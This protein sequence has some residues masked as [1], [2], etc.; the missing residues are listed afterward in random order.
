M[1]VTAYS[2]MS[3]GARI[4]AARDCARLKTDKIR[5]HAV[6]LN[7]GTINRMCALCAAWGKWARPETSLDLFLRGFRGM[8]LV[9]E[10]NA[11]TQ[12]DPDDGEE[13][14]EEQVAEAAAILKASA[15]QSEP[16]DDGEAGDED[17]RDDDED[18]DEESNDPVAD[19]ETLRDETVRQWCD[20]AKS[21]M[22]AA[23]PIARY[24]WLE[25]WASDYMALKARRAETLRQRA[26]RLLDEAPLIA[27]SAAAG[28]ATPDLPVDD[29]AFA[30][31]GGP[32]QARYALSSLWGEWHSRVSHERT[33]PSAH[34]YLAYTMEDLLGGKRKGREKLR[35]RTAQILHA[36]AGAAAAEAAQAQIKPDRLLLAVIRKSDSPDAARAPLYKA[37]TEWEIGVLI[38]FTVAADWATRTFLLRVPAAVATRLI[39]DG[40]RLECV[41][42]DGDPGKPEVFGSLLASASEDGRR[43]AGYNAFLPGARDDTPVCQR[44]P[45]ALAEVRALREA[46]D[47]Q[48]QLFLVCSLSGGVEV[49][50]LAHVQERCEQ[51]WSG[52]LIA[53]ADDLPLGLIEPAAGDVTRSTDADNGSGIW[54]SR[55][56]E[57]PGS[58]KFGEHLGI[59]DGADRLYRLLCLR[60]DYTDADRALRVLALARGIH[61]LR[62]IGGKYESQPGGIPWESW[63]ALVVEAHLDLGPFLPVESESARDGGLGLPLAGLAGVQIYS[64]NADP[65]TMGKGHSPF[66]QHAGRH[67]GIDRSYDLITIS[68]LMQAADPDWCSKCGGYVV[69]RLTRAQVHYYRIAHQLL[70]LEET[71]ASEFRGHTWNRADLAAADQSLE[72][73]ESWLNDQRQEWWIADTW[74]MEAVL[75]DIRGKAAQVRRQREEG[76][77]GNGTV[78]QFSPK[79]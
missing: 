13:P 16:T 73:A 51:G 76:E 20:A 32:P 75:R 64:T 6:P 26:A 67:D 25:P 3:Q 22:D 49:L 52:I 10:L 66:C 40:Y 12:A 23:G 53:E 21:L 58:E 56:Y 14:T 1:L 48:H 69:R 7:S 9:H 61:D 74:R 70:D 65:K 29:P 50:S 46:L 41:E 68:D 17:D 62:Q 5:E 4:H 47:E 72:A 19:A 30:V 63:H 31:L 28:M 15:R 39:K 27:V 35:R 37:L 34:S 55:G 54:N 8:G 60:S 78:V 45:V 38:M 11:Y 77:Q 2:A 79:R 33:V 59:D 42:C 57:P 24:P 43:E 18:E 44:R 36:W 71:L